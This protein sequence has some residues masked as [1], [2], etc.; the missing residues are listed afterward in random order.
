MHLPFWNTLG[1]WGFWDR[2]CQ[3][4]IQQ[5]WQEGG[6]QNA[7]RELFTKRLGVVKEKVNPEN[8]TVSH[9][10]GFLA[11]WHLVRPSPVTP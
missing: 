9:N 5:A 11:G 6:G 4:W 1:G 8:L 3:F 7:V 10:R 2:R